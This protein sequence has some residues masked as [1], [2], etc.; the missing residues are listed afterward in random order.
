MLL[1]G[2]FELTPEAVTANSATPESMGGSVGG[3]L[4]LTPSPLPAKL[5]VLDTSADRDHAR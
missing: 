2:P 1:A 3:P 4:A 5:P